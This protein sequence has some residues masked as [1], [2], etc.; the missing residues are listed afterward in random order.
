MNLQT[1]TKTDFDW[2]SLN[3]EL[4]GV[5]TTEGMK[6]WLQKYKQKLELEQQAIEDERS[7]YLDIQ[8]KD[9]PFRNDGKPDVFTDVKADD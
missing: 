4:K 3:E 6:A 9:N 5:N 2:Q 7:L 1:G 8:G